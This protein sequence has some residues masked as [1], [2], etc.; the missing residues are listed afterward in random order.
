MPSP[1]PKKVLLSHRMWWQHWSKYHQPGPSKA[2]FFG[3]EVGCNHLARP[4]TNHQ[5]QLNRKC[6]IFIFIHFPISYTFFLFF[7]HSTFHK[8]K[9]STYNTRVNWFRSVGGIQIKTRPF[10]CLVFQYPLKNPQRLLPLCC[11]STCTHHCSASYDARPYTT[12]QH[13]YEGSPNIIRMSWQRIFPLCH[14]FRKM[15]YM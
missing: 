1:F 5:C 6:S 9:L 13:W 4:P 10:Q 14:K 2:T 11:P 8:Q 12:G 7:S 3:G 15:A